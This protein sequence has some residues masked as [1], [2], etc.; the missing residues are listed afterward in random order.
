MKRTDSFLLFSLLTVIPCSLA[1]AQVETLATWE[2]EAEGDQF[3][4]AVAL[5]GDF[6]GDGRA[7]LAVGASTND[8]GGE[9]A[10]KVFLYLGGTPPA[11]L[12]ALELIGTTGSF[13][14]SAV[15]WAGDVDS[16]GYDDLL[17]GAYRD[18]EGGVNAGKA[19]LFRGGDPLDGTADL[20]LLG[21]EPG[22]YFGRVVA[23][24]GDLDADGIDDFA[25][26]APR[27]VEGE[28][29]LYFGSESLD[30]NA[31]LVLRGEADGD[32]F[33]SSIAGIGNVDGQAGNDL[34]IGASRASPDLTWQGTV[35]VFSGGTSLDS[36]ADWSFSGEGAGDHLGL[37]VAAAG[38]VDDDGFADF[39]VG[40][41]YR[42]IGQ[43]TD[44]GT[45]YLVFGG[46]PIGAYDVRFEGEST[47]ENLGYALVGCGDVIGN[48]L[49][50][51]LIGAPGYDGSR[52]DVGRAI[53]I[54]G[55]DPP[56][57]A[58]AIPFEGEFSDDQFGFAVAGDPFAGTSFAGAPSPDLLVGA[59]GYDPAGKSY[60][61]GLPGDGSSIE[62]TH[63]QASS[64]E[65]LRVRPLSNPSDSVQL[66]IQ[67]SGRPERR[68]MLLRLAIYGSDG[69]RLRTWS[70]TDPA[71]SFLWSADRHLGNGPPL[72]PGIYFIRVHGN[73]GSRGE[74]R[75]V[76]TR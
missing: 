47:E 39:L 8:E 31:D 19:Y 9:N 67:L 6:N 56:D 60:V 58:D 38:D 72:A 44:A 21:T 73:D 74:T 76:L 15:A 17:I 22:A 24:V 65:R 57:P 42:N 36:I 32:R 20:V 5:G 3:G 30:G 61:M 63:T 51:L 27:A 7:D 46:D 16:D 43:W 49:P 1:L 53:L 10:G 62:Q 25:V 28:T 11:E 26:G 41:P 70:I 18:D 71:S 40:A 50:D 66:R 34:L 12:P 52:A 4:V 33:G 54:P 69:R 45:A 75:I 37:S 29:H 68:A 55:G 23:G 14:G 64:G 59:W 13:F 48:G 35:S 2:G